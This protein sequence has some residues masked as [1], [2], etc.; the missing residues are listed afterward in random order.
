MWFRILLISSVALSFSVALHAQALSGVITDEAGEPV[1]WATVFV[2]ELMYG[3]VAN[4]DG[5]FELK[6]DAGD[7]TCVFQSM[8]YQAETREVSIGKTFNPLHIHLKPMVY[9]LSG[10]VVS[11]SG[12][13]TPPTALCVR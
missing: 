8:G 3:T 10:V 5:A 11:S 1:P 2:K 9:N 12:E 13:R 4:Q 7:Y 6:L